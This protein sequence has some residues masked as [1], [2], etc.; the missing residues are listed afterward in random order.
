ML[1]ICFQ[2]NHK[3][4]KIKEK[5]GEIFF[6]KKG[7]MGSNEGSYPRVPVCCWSRFESVEASF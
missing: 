6:T 5:N 3:N 4:T 1:N 2:V 7:G